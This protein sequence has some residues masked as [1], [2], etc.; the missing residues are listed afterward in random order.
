M[1]TFNFDDDNVP[2]ITY[3][4]LKKWGVP[5]GRRHLYRRVNQGKFPPPIH[6]S[7]R[8]RLWTRSQLKSIIK[9]LR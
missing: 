5:W 7:D 4:D 1:D 8:K 9:T 6:W 2:N 3:N